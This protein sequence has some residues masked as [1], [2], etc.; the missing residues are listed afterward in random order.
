MVSNGTPLG[1]MVIQLDLDSTKVGD[2][3]TRG[4]NQLRNFE[5]QIL[6]NGK[7]KL[8]KTVLNG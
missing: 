3:M 7:T 6:Y 4:K 1:Q 8:E 2:A 5:K